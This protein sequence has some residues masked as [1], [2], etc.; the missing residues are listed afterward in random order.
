M[1]KGMTDGN[2]GTWLTDI[3][4]VCGETEFFFYLIL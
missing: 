3:L 2:K 4:G 1:L